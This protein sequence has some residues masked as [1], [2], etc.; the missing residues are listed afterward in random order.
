[1]SFRVG[2]E[3]NDE[4]FRTIVWA[5]EYP[6]CFAY[7]KDSREALANLPEAIQKYTGWL[8]SHGEVWFDPHE[9]EA[10][11][12]ETF[13]AYILNEDFERVETGDNEISAW[14]L[15]DWKPLAAQDIA[16][17]LKLL[18]WFRED[19]LNT[20]KGLSVEKLAMKY[21]GERWSINGIL[22]HT[23]GA[24]WWYLDRL[25]LAF[26]KSELPRDPLARLEKVRA[27][28]NNIL[29]TLEGSL[30]V[31]GSEGE[32]WSP[33]KVLRRAIWHECDHTIHIRKLL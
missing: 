17:G 29:P 22:N 3:N 30:Q 33:R 14:F 13:D 20:I 24:E 25:G 5:L 1:M 27:S 7:G 4:G 18:A 23:G 32:I 16:R 2:I 15:H 19:L 10:R 21:E 11:L 28:F 12:E 8:A 31:V 6:G 26:P 9:A